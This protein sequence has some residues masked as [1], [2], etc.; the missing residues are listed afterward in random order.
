MSR[1]ARSKKL[2]DPNHFKFTADELR[3][4]KGALVQFKQ[5]LLDDVW[6]T[7][8]P[9]QT[10]IVTDVEIAEMARGKVYKSTIHICTGRGIVKVNYKNRSIY[11]LCLEGG[12]EYTS[13]VPLWSQYIAEELQTEYLTEEERAEDNSP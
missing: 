1:V 11:V 13:P 8:T 6:W 2:T 3:G 9:L 10:G 4:L 12:S 7:T 5:K